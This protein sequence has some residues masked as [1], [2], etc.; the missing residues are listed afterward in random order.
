MVLYETAEPSLCLHE[1]TEELVEKENQLEELTKSIEGLKNQI[2]DFNM[3]KESFV[4]ISNLSRDFVKAHTTAD[5]ERLRELLS[6]DLVLEERERKLYVKVQ[7]YDWVLFDYNDQGSFD[8]WVIQGYEFSRE[9]NTYSVFI[10]EFYSDVNGEPVSPPT[11]L[12]LVFEYQ[13]NGWEVISLG[14]D[15]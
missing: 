14:F 7:G 5:K 11:F 13:E 6:E 15:V 4:F 12:N 8:D 1:L 9:N 2:D 10:R 3:E